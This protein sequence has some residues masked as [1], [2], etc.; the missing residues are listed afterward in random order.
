MTQQFRKSEPVNKSSLGTSAFR[1]EIK[2]IPNVTFFCTKANI[3]AIE[4]PTILEYNPNQ[5]F[6]SPGDKISFSP[7]MV[8]F[9]LDED[10]TNYTEI[11]NWLVGMSVFQIGNIP[12][13]EDSDR[14]SDASLF[15]LT[16]S[17]NPNKIIKYHDI[18][19][20]GL[21]SV[22]FDSQVTSIDYVDVVAS[23]GYSYFT[24]ESV[25]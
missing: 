10:L 11:F 7:L 5:R 13:L 24:I 16:N 2:R 4:L 21:S 1:L 23:F 20:M 12:I 9:K 25:V 22:D 19:P 15:T 17:T 6:S 14:F 18:Y 8:Q 3:P